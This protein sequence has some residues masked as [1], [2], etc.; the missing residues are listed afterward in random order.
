MTILL[1]KICFR[2]LSRTPLPNKNE[3]PKGWSKTDVTNS[4][5]K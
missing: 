2:D 5:L 4:D 3:K 1:Y